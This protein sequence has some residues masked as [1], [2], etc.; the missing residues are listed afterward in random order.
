MGRTRRERVMTHVNRPGEP[1]EAAKRDEPIIDR[2]GGHT[3][4][5]GSAVGEETGSPIGRGGRIDHEQSRD[6]VQEALEE[7]FPASDPPSYT[8]TTGCGPPKHQEPAA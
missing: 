6:A 7:S 3:D 5:T 1:V 4:P 8:S 2:E